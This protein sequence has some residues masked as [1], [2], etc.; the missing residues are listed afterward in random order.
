MKVV[1]LFRSYFLLFLLLVFRSAYS[2]DIFKLGSDLKEPQQQEREQQVRKRADIAD[3]AEGQERS[4]DDTLPHEQ[5][6][7]N[8]GN[9]EVNTHKKDYRLLRTT[10]FPLTRS[11][12]HL[13]DIASY[14]TPPI[15]PPITPPRKQNLT[16][17]F[18]KQKSAI[19][20]VLNKPLLYLE[21]IIL[22]ASQKKQAA[23]DVAKMNDDSLTTDAL[24]LKQEEFTRLGNLWIKIEEMSSLLQEDRH[25][26]RELLTQVESS[27]ASLESEKQMGVEKNFSESEQVV[28]NGIVLLNRT[29]TSHEKMVFFS[30]RAAEIIDAL[31]HG[32]WSSWDESGQELGLEQMEKENCYKNNVSILQLFAANHAEDED[33]RIA[34]F[35]EKV[36]DHEY[37]EMQKMNKDRNDK[38]MERNKNILEFCSDIDFIKEKIKEDKDHR[39]QTD[40][41]EEAMFYDE[42]IQWHKNNCE[43]MMEMVEQLMSDK[44]VD[45]VLQVRSQK[46]NEL[47]D[48]CENKATNIRDLAARSHIPCG[49]E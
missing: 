28:Q 30:F 33:E 23:L 29:I 15:T 21:Q 4:T 39:L 6:N 40:H 24:S 13:L 41:K 38:I 16:A 34:S 9:N 17:L 12:N 14:V 48:E 18:L 49:S 31:I 32:V 37:A 1:P 11:L 43:I 27:Q 47:A 5:Q 25:Q 35:F 22:T 7:V 10:S 26:L 20:T 45:P 44:Q 3:M 46:L 36:A 19:N 42:A 2:M 8:S